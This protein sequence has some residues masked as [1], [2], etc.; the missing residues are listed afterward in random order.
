MKPPLLRQLLLCNSLL[1]LRR[2]ELMY[3]Q[4]RKPARSCKSH[5]PPGNNRLP[6]S[7]SLQDS[8]SGWYRPTEPAATQTLAVV[9]ERLGISLRLT[10]CRYSPMCPGC[11]L[12][13]P[14]ACNEERGR[15]AEIN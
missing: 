6:K 2:P 11:V 13:I 5:S 3:Q 12:R 4:P 14:G 7:R 8:G 1:V 10:A 15:H 9:A